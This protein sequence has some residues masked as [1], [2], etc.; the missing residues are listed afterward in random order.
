VIQLVRLILG[1]GNE[2]MGDDGAGNYVAARIRKLGWVAYDCGT[3]PENFTGKV[4]ELFPEILVLVDTACMNIRPGEFRIVPPEYIADVA[5]GTHALSLRILI[6]YLAPY[7]VRILFI[8]IQP[9]RVEPGTLLTVPVQDGAKRLASMIEKEA[10]DEI[11]V[12]APVD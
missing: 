3:V 5:F 4:K 1:I 2:L 10:F 7:A 9:E 6:D 8:G 11:E 12:Y